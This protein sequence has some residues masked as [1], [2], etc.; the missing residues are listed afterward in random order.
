M[1]LSQSEKHLK[2]TDGF[3]ISQRRT[4]IAKVGGPTYYMVIYF[5]KHCNKMKEIE[6][7]R[8]PPMHKISFK[9]LRCKLI[10]L[11]YCY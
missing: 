1:T 3:I 2:I 11:Y 6:P 10:R 5:L 8:G 4:A 9:R 7:K